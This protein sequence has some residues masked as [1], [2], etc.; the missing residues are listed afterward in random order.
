MSIVNR[1]VKILASQ[2]DLRGTLPDNLPEKLRSESFEVIKEVEDPNGKSANG[3]SLALLMPY[4]IGHIGNAGPNPKSGIFGYD[5]E[6]RIR[7]GWWVYESY[8]EVEEC[9]PTS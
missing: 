6:G 9:L 3:K 7:F 8:C 5:Q 4:G 2:R 1:R